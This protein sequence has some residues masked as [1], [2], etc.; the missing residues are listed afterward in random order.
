MRLLQPAAID[1]E[2]WSERGDL[3]SRPDPP[4]RALVFFRYFLVGLRHFLSLKNN[5]ISEKP[6]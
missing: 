3:D 5:D 6:A 1:W 4:G 2:S